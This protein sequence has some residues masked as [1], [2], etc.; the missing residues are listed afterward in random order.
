MGRKFLITATALDKRGKKI[1]SAQNN[2]FRTHPLQAKYAK[3]VGLDKKQSLH[4]EISCIIRA[5][6]KE[7]HKIKIERYDASGN[8][9]LSKPCPIC[10]MAIKEAGIKFVEYT[11]G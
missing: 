8:P 11:V 9:K 7:I 6:G 2:Y 10:E 5:K 1:S 3:H 4:A